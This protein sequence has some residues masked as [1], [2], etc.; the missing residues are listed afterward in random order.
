KT[1]ETEALVSE[2]LK[3][4]DERQVVVEETAQ[5][6]EEPV[7]DVEAD[8]V[9]L[10]GGERVLEVSREE[11]IP[12]GIELARFE[13]SEI[14][15]TE[16]VITDVIDSAVERSVQEVPKEDLVVREVKAVEIQKEPEI[17]KA[18]VK[19]LVKKEEVR[20][21]FVAEKPKG[22]KTEIKKV[23]KIEK[24]EDVTVE[25]T[26]VVKEKAIQVKGQKLEEKTRD[27]LEETKTKETSEKAPIISPYVTRGEVQQEILRK[28]GVEKEGSG[29]QNQTEVISNVTDQSSSQEKIL[30]FP[31]S[32]ERAGILGG[33][34]NGQ[35]QAKDE[36][37]AERHQTDI[38]PTSGITLRRVA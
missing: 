14:E 20:A 15:A 1:Q 5:E 9:V 19:E 36:V 33:A 25:K 28:V 38:D 30:H 32:R 27:K 22:V 21:A 31:E 3:I 24:P 6:M 2:T 16:P 10:E 11:E 12:T 34:G 17:V 8:A 35:S 23:E 13:E 29:D 7:I 18:E 4:E 37:E 26:Q